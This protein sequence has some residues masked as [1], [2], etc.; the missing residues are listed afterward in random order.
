MPTE[1]GQYIYTIRTGAVER[2][3]NVHVNKSSIEVNPITDG[4]ALY[5]SSFSRSN[6]ETDTRSI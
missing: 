1:I 5:L 3:F 2:V 4:L 6:S